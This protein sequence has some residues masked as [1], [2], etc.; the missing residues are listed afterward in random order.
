M[1]FINFREQRTGRIFQADARRLSLSRFLPPITNNKD[2]P[3]D[4]DY[5]KRTD[6]MRQEF[7]DVVTLSDRD[8]H[9]K[10]AEIILACVRNDILLLSDGDGT[11]AV[12]EADAFVSRLEPG[13]HDAMD[14]IARTGNS[15]SYLITGRHEEAAFSII[16]DEL[17]FPV[18]CDHGAVFL[19]PDGKGSKIELTPAQEEFVRRAHQLARQIEQQYPGLTVQLKYSGIDIKDDSGLNIENIRQ[20]LHGLCA[21]GGNPVIDGGRTAF[22]VYDGEGSVETSI[23]FNG[24]DKAKS[25]EIFILPSLNDDVP[26][27]PVFLCDSLGPHGTDRRLAEMVQ[28][29]GGIVIQVL[30]DRPDCMPEEGSTFKPDLIL[31]NPGAA[32]LLLQ[33]I[34]TRRADLQQPITIPGRDNKQCRPS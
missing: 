15:R 34:S 16:A 24:V 33:Q 18:I 7:N 3:I 4:P 5:K 21:S 19:T 9:L 14:V 12:L 28:D 26:R 17:K 30:N 8:Y 6:Y 1:A 27:L 25:F 13:Y 10:L 32:R 31:P 11:G 2:V 20:R 22:S 29:M 23:R